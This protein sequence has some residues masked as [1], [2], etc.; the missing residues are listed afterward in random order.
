MTSSLS[1]R[2][3]RCIDALPRAY[4]GPGGAVAMLRD[5][6]TLVRH[7]WGWANAERRIAFTP[8]TLFRMCSI[9]KQFTCGRGAGRLPRSLGA[10]Q[11]CPCPPAAPGAPPP[12]ALHLC[13]NQ[14]GLRDYWALAMLHGSPPEAPFGDIEAAR[15]DRRRPD[16]AVRARHPLLVRQP[17]FPHSLRHP[18]GRAPAA[19]SPNCCAPASSSLPACQPHCW[20]PT[21]APC[22]TARRATRARRPTA[23]APP[24]TASCGPAMPGSAPASTT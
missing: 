22:R 19:A 1:A 10:G 24:R 23:S 12:A 21:P 16:P 20:P 13:H 6:K 7:A 2:L 11:R 17:E 18:A 15:R 5:G 4:P 14:S 8:R 3:D 9:T